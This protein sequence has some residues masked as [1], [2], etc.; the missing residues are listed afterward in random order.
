MSFQLTNLKAQRE[1]AGHTITSLAALANVSDRTVQSLENQ[2][3]TD[4]GAIV[5]R[6]ADVL[7]VSLVTL[8]AV[9]Q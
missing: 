8:G 2:N 6:L 5:Q 1:A 4:D 3:G 9:E 7:G